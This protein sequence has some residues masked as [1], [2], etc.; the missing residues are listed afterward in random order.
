MENE[1][2]EIV[3][4]E[5]NKV[6]RLE[7]AVDQLKTKVDTLEKG[8]S[9]QNLRLDTLE[10]E[11]IKKD[12]RL[13]N[14]EISMKQILD[15]ILWIKRAMIKGAIGIGTSIMGAAIVG[16]VVFYFNNK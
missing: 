13:Q 3:N 16:L 4:D 12:A 14:V 15:N 11:D 5:D 9:S 1:V 2:T 6:I 8:E 10:K 7:L